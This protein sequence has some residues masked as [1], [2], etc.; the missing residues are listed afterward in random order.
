MGAVG[1]DA[2]EVLQL[3][4]P[5]ASAGIARV[6]PGVLRPETRK[7]AQAPVEHRSDAIQFRPPQ[8]RERVASDRIPPYR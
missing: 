7:F 8:Q 5:V 4:L 6:I 3:K 1:A 2:K